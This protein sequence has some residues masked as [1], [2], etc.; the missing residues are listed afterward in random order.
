MDLHK[1]N[2]HLH[3]LLTHAGNRELSLLCNMQILQRKEIYTNNYD[4]LKTYKVTQKYQMVQR[5]IGKG[6]YIHWVETEKLKK[7]RACGKTAITGR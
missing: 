5:I 2:K 3:T 4:K 7:K 1:F 6:N